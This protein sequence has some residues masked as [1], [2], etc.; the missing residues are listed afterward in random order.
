MKPDLVKEAGKLIFTEELRSTLSKI[1]ADSYSERLIQVTLP[2]K[3]NN[4]TFLAM[5]RRNSNLCK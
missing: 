2:K 3:E 1:Q 4:L 5:E